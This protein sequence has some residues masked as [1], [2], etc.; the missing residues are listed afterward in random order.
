[1]KAQ[2]VELNTDDESEQGHHGPQYT[3]R[4]KKLRGIT[5]NTS[6]SVDDVF[7]PSFPLAVVR[8]ECT[9]SLLINLPAAPL[10]SLASLPL[11]PYHCLST[12]SSDYIQ[13]KPLCKVLRRSACLM[14]HSP[15]VPACGM[16]G[17]EGLQQAPNS[18][19]GD[20]TTYLPREIW[21]GVRREALIHHNKECWLQNPKLPVYPLQGA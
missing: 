20:L 4:V 18:N 12:W 9:L 6:L 1:M 21:S 2:Q 13:F 15:P 8:K 14:R 11:A 10:S 7:R 17:T 5:S 3:N 16:L 19:T